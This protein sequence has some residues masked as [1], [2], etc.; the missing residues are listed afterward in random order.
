MNDNL[1]HEEIVAS[2][3]IVRLIE[4]LTIVNV[5][6]VK[7]IYSSSHKDSSSQCSNQ[8]IVACFSRAQY[9]T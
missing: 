1:T 9:S 2:L 7:D 8:Q 6:D 3:I 5:I 4:R